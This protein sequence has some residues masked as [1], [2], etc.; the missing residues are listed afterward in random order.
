M[1]VILG[2]SSGMNLADVMDATHELETGEQ[3]SDA[4]LSCISHG[5]RRVGSWFSEIRISSLVRSGGRLTPGA[6]TSNPALNC[7]GHGDGTAAGLAAKATPTRATA[8]P[9]RAADV[10]T[11]RLPATVARSDQP[12]Y[13]RHESA[14][15]AGTS[16]AGATGLEPATSGVTGR[17][18][19][20]LSY[21]PGG[22]FQ[23]SQARP[24]SGGPARDRPP[25]LSARQ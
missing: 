22:G 3:Q 21:A 5:A 1:P 20:Q 23:V 6:Q 16:R 10:P 19:N 2:A 12:G 13:L 11:G 18:S 17:R 8:P 7:R 9:Y 15:F 24:S 14:R 4:P 25:Q